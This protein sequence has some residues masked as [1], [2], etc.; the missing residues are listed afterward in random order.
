MLVLPA[1]YLHGTVGQVFG[2]SPSDKGT[3]KLV[4]V[5]LNVIPTSIEMGRFLKEK[6]LRQTLRQNSHLEDRKSQAK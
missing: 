2:R 5:C 6:M 1:K 4:A 3:E